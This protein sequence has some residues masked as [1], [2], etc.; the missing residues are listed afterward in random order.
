MVDGILNLIFCK[1]W[2]GVVLARIC[3]V[4]FSARVHTF[5]CATF[6]TFIQIFREFRKYICD[7][8]SRI[9]NFA[10]FVLDFGDE[11]MALYNQE[12]LRRS[13]KRDYHRLTMC[14]KL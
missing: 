9:D 11:I 3:F 8:L 7:S 6:F 5:F 14:V 2:D 13:G 12:T 10:F 4:I 1:L